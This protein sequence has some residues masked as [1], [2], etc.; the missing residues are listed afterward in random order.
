[1]GRNWKRAQPQGPAPRQFL[2][3]QINAVPFLRSCSWRSP[4]LSPPRSVAFK[5]LSRSSVRSRPEADDPDRA[6]LDRAFAQLALSPPL[7]PPLSPCPSPA[8]APASSPTIRGTRPAFPTRSYGGTASDIS[9][10]VPAEALVLAPASPWAGL[11]ALVR[12]P[13]HHHPGVPA[14]PTAA[15]PASPVSN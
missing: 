6:T 15:A 11:G 14:E 12:I 10:Q 9:R 1:M 2:T 3:R 8:P 13:R 7:W 4:S 5:S